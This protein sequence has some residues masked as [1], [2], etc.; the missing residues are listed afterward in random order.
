MLHRFRS[1]WVT[2]AALL[3]LLALGPLQA[4]AHA[5]AG[6]PSTSNSM[7]GAIMAIGCGASTRVAVVTQQPIVIAV[8]IVMCAFMLID[9]MATPDGSPF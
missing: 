9:A 6:E 8:T 2:A 4:P 3:A 5:Q 1:R 7:A